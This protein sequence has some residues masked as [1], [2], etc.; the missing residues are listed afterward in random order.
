MTSLGFLERTIIVIFINIYNV[1]I[2]FLL[3]IKSYD[4]KS[5]NESATVRICSVSLLWKYSKT[6]NSN[7]SQKFKINWVME[8]K[9]SLA[10][11]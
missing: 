5:L 3:A 4:R 2:Q 6:I 9:Y 10:N 1:M 8:K 11:N 7:C